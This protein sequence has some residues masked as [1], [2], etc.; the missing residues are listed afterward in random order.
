MFRPCC[1]CVSGVPNVQRRLTPNVSGLPGDGLECALGVFGV[2][3]RCAWGV[4][5]VSL[6]SVLGGF[7][8][9]CS[10][11]GFPLC[12][13]YAWGGVQGLLERSKN[14]LERS[15]NPACNATQII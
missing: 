8:V 5:E 6:E 2:G 4:L 3:F 10:F 1:G 7:E 14:V 11:G 12:F 9:R 15:R 13:G